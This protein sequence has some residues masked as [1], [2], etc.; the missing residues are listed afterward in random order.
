MAALLYKDFLIIAFGMF[1][2]DKDLWIPRVDVSWRSASGRQS[3]TVNDSINCFGSKLEAETFALDIAKAWIDARPTEKEPRERN[4]EMD[5]FLAP[6]AT[7]A[8]SRISRSGH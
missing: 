8:G 6:T 5:V 2:K 1:D 7:Q 4:S 3:H